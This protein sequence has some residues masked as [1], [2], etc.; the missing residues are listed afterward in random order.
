MYLAGH[1]VTRRV[2]SSLLTSVR[3]GTR[4]F[5]TS[6]DRP[7]YKGGT[8]LRVCHVG[9]EGGGQF[10]ITQTKYKLT[11][12]IKQGDGQKLC[13]W[14]PFDVL[15]NR[16]SNHVSQST[17]APNALPRSSMTSARRASSALTTISPW[18]S[19]SAT[20]AC[21]FSLALFHVLPWPHHMCDCS[22]ERIDHG[23]LLRWTKGFGAANVEGHDVVE[24]LSKALEKHVSLVAHIDPHISKSDS[25]DLE[26]RKSPSK[27]LL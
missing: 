20:R 24:I 25:E 19:L 21:T 7:R 13:K 22:Q 16:S 4:S 15:A 1:P 12:E 14:W 11:E 10:E 17:F 8:N 6:S 18:G 2:D 3:A 9:L 26:N 5:K 23:V 27:S